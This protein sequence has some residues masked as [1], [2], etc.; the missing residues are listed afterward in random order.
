MVFLSR[1]AIN[2]S[3]K[4]LNNPGKIPLL[5]R[6]EREAASMFRGGYKREIDKESRHSSLRAFFLEKMVC[7]SLVYETHVFRTV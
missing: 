4:W 6:P 5:H 2:S 1:M 7:R 3:G